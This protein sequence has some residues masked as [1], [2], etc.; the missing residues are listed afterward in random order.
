MKPL[1]AALLAAAAMN[2][3]AAAPPPDDPYLWLEDVQGE[4]AL[5]WVRARNA[6]SRAALE[7]HPRFEAMRSRILEVLDSRDKIPY[8]A[9]RGDALYNFWQD[10]SHPR[11]LWRRTTLAEY[12]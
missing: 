12:L 1:I 2:I 9:R 10:A 8:V 11:G 7:K 4:R 3:P 6:H 5:D